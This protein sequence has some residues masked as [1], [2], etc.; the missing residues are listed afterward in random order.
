MKPHNR[1]LPDKAA[2]NSSSKQK[3]LDS[4]KTIL[5]NPQKLSQNLQERCAAQNTT[6]TTKNKN[7]N[8]NILWKEPESTIFERLRTKLELD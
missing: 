2:Y 4:P 7:K 5:K 1:A 3:V 6:K 8:K